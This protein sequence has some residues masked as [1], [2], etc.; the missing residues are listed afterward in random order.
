MDQGSLADS[1]IMLIVT[2]S[3][4]AAILVVFLVAVVLFALL[5]VTALLGV[6]GFAFVVTQLIEDLVMYLVKVA[7]SALAALKKRRQGESWI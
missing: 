6:I 5:A 1:I 3:V 2:V 7:K 4:L